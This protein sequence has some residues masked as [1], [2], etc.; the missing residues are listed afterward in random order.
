MVMHTWAHASGNQSIDTPSDYDLPYPGGIR[1][2]EMVI[3]A[4][5][6]ALYVFGGT[7]ND[8]SGNEGIY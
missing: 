4:T 1:G 5:H 6:S 7:G 2:H 8:A 3:D